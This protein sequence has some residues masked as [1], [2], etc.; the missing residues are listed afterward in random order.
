MVISVSSSTE[1][2]LEDLFFRV[3]AG[4]PGVTLNLTILSVR[5]IGSLSTTKGELQFLASDTRRYSGDYVIEISYPDH[6]QRRG[7]SS[8][9]GTANYT[10]LITSE[11]V[12]FD[13]GS[14]G[15]FRIDTQ[16]ITTFVVVFVSS[17]L[18]SLSATYIIRRARE[19]ALLLRA[20][21]RGELAVMPKEPP[22]FFEVELAVD[23]D[24]LERFKRK[25]FESADNGGVKE[26]DQSRD[27]GKG[28]RRSDDVELQILRT[29][30]ME[31]DDAGDPSMGGQ[32]RKFS[33]DQIR[34][35]SFH[36]HA[37]GVARNLQT[38]SAFSS[39]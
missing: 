38:D 2:A 28:E 1:N 19:R 23:R 22:P 4:N 15:G 16:D 3:I 24:T 26:K 36:I 21:R 29:A 6:L 17:V 35:V 27:A 8:V 10:V 39:H 7:S 32:A 12:I 31:D 30:R 20:I 37:W 9:P 33:T 34:Y 11:Q 18:V 14:G 5:P 25:R 13:D